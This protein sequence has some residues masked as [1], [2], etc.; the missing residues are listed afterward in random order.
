MGISRKKKPPVVTPEVFPAGFF[1]K[2]AR[3]AASS[4]NLARE[5]F[6]RPEDKERLCGELESMYKTAVEE[7]YKF[8]EQKPPRPH[9]SLYND[10]LFPLAEQFLTVIAALHSIGNRASLVYENQGNKRIV[11]VNRA[12]KTLDIQRGV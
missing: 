4:A 7:I 1:E 11:F 5:I 3:C 8:R 10:F 6:N 9:R 2:L 12:Q